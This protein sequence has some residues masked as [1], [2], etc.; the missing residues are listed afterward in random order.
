MGSSSNGRALRCGIYMHG[1]RSKLVLHRHV[2]CLLGIE[3]GAMLAH[4]DGLFVFLVLKGV[5]EVGGLG[6]L[7]VHGAKLGHHRV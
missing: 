6:S 3:R 5:F 1:R 4:S 2:R 7:E